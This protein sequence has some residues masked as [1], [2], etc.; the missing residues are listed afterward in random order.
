MSR[1]TTFDVFVPTQESYQDQTATLITKQNVEIQKTIN[2]NISAEHFR[3]LFDPYDDTTGVFNAM[4]LLD[5]LRQFFSQKSNLALFASDLSNVITYNYPNVHVNPRK[6]TKLVK[7][8]ASL[9]NQ[10]FMANTSLVHPDDSSTNTKTYEEIAYSIK[11]MVDQSETETADE[12]FNGLI[13][14]DC[15]TISMKLD[16]SAFSTT[17]P[18]LPVY[19]KFNVVQSASSYTFSL[20]STSS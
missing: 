10:L 11:D 15:V 2:I 8:D 5:P 19:V 16:V 18:T 20:D 7:A 9:W 6:L 4:L 1:T 13:A 3:A 14:G 12:V 17:N